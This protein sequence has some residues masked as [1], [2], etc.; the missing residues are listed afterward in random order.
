M[1]NKKLLLF[2]A[3]VIAILFMTVGYA[4]IGSI[5]G[6]IKGNAIAKLQDGVFITDVEYVSDN[7][8]KVN[9]S[10]IEKFVGT[11]MKSTVEL[12][13]TNVDSSITYKVT[14]YN[15]YADTAVF[16]DV[17]Y[18]DEFYDNTDI[19]FEITGFKPGEKI[20]PSESKDIIITFKYSGTTVPSN[21]VLNSYLNFKIT[22]PNRMMIASTG[23]SSSTN[24]LKGSIAKNKIETITFKLGKES[25]IS[26][27]K[28]KS[29]FDASEK[30][31][32]SIIGY[33]TDENDDGMYDLTFLSED[34]IYANKNA[35]YLFNYL[36]N[37]KSIDFDNFRTDDVTSMSSMF[38]NCNSLTGLNVSEFDTSN[39]TSM[40][41]MFNECK[42]LMSL[43]VSNFNTKNVTRMSSMFNGC[44]GL[45]S[46]D[47]SNFNTSNVIDMSS[48]FSDCRGLTSL[49]VAN[50]NTSNVSRMDYMFS[51]CSGLTSLDV[52]NLNTSNV[53]SMY[54]MFGGC[55]GLTSL[56]VSDFN[57]SNV[58]NMANMFDSCRSL[59]TIYVTEYD[60]TTGKGWTT[61]KVTNSSMMFSYC[62]KLVGGN[63]TVYDSSNTDATYARIDTAENPGYLTGPGPYLPK[64][65]RQVSG[66]TL[67]NGL[68]IQD[69]SGNQYV[70]VEVPKTKEVYPTA[71]LEITEFTE[72]EYTAIETDLHTYTN[73]YIE[74]GCEDTYY[75]DAA[76]G[77]TSEQYTQLKQKMLKSVYQNGGFYIGKYETG[78]ETARTSGDASTA[79]TDTPVIKQN[80]YPYNYVTCSQAQTLATTKMESGD[81]T[82]SLLFGVQWDLTLKYLETKGT[83]QADLKTD[84][85]SWENYQN[86]AWSITNVNLKYAVYANNSLGSW[87]TATEKS[88]TSSESIL[89]ST[90]AD[91]S[92]SKMGIYD[93]AGNEYEWT[94]EYTSNTYYPCALRGGRYSNSGSNRPAITRNGNFATILRDD[95]GFRLALY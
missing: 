42:G 62:Y 92:F 13:D 43:D 59:T 7:E 29:Q 6:D 47:V 84:S 22:V 58:T 83:S 64:G 39:V 23:G 94:L 68:T 20:G 77:L 33:Y 2:L 32:E 86:N 88:K 71:G 31:D 93:L 41:G 27:T 80:V 35:S 78:T 37:L 15:S 89:L 55:S 60:S 30:Q 18:G 8:A 36:S 72:Y 81:R 38:S 40:S 4:S 76:T 25:D 28:V 90:G 50:F 61:E 1:K 34:T 11:M 19:T 24:Y 63:G 57:T 74:S 69:G 73:D 65:F 91:D 21:K 67:D 95:V 44:S 49:D 87:T 3:L 79:P 10:K 54:F 45:T 66:T 9:S 26:V 53:T 17:L 14:V 46:L 85:T 16:S 52:S 70:W 56:D 51:G 75:S 5:T 82:T 12:S 48:V